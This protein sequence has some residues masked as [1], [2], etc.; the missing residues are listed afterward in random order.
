[1]FHS[2]IFGIDTRRCGDNVIERCGRT[3]SFDENIFYL[4]Y[5]SVASTAVRPATSVQENS[6]TGNYGRPRQ[7]EWAVRLKYFREQQ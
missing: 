1:M 7:A 2:S 3:H 4:I 5:G 6:D